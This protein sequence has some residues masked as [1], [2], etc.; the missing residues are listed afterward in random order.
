MSKP[1]FATPRES[2]QAQATGL[3]KVVY[4]DSGQTEIRSQDVNELEDVAKAL[5]ADP[6]AI[7]EL[8]KALPIRAGATIQSRARPRTRGGRDAPI[9]CNVTASST[10]ARAITMGKVTLG[11]GEKQAR[12]ALARPGG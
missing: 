4:F 7:L 8:Q 9:S 11:A 3:T 2:Q 10:S 6:N 1:A 12:E 5:T